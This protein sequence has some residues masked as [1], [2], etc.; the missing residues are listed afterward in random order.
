VRLGRMGAIHLLDEGKNLLLVLLWNRALKQ[1][2]QRV[3]VRVDVRREPERRAQAAVNIMGAIVF[4]GFAG[5]CPY[6]AR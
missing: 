4:K 1:R 6:E 2:D 5:K 3:F